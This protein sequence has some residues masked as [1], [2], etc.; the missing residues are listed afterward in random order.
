MPPEQAT[1]RLYG[2]GVGPGDPELLTLRAHRILSR[3]PVIVMPGNNDGKDGYARSIISGLLKPEQEVLE[4]AFP[5][6][7]DRAVLARSWLEAAEAIY[8]RLRQAKDC[9]FVSE[10]DPL[11]FGTFIYVLR[12]LRGSHPGLRV[13]VIAGISSI[14][15]AA[16]RTIV[17]LA[18]GD[19][20]IAV[21]PAGSGEALIRR[22]LRD[23]D[24]V[25]FLKLSAAFERLLAVIGQMGLTANCVYVRRCSTPQ[26]V[27]VTNIEELAGT[28]PDYFSLLIM[29]K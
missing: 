2:V 23:F 24:T 14:N 4:M 20:S 8:S 17:P 5:M 3:V 27:V 13:E 18:S 6:T 15:A 7:R 29:R 12:A 25:V 22:A 28:K 16:A 1:G 26:E 9:A 11:L 10:G 19:E 21:L